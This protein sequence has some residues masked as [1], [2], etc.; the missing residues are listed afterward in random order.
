M[1]YYKTREEIEKIRQSCLLV[2][3]TL[4]EV[5]KHIRPGI[6]TGELD[7]TGDQFIRDHQGVPAFLGYRGFP[8]SLCISVNEQVVHGIPGS[9]VLKEGDIVSVDCGVL[10]NKFYGDS[11]YTFPVGEVSREKKN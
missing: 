6:T 2:S 11:A 3:R 4:A 7:K 5:S 8:K 10:L 9:Y 1:V